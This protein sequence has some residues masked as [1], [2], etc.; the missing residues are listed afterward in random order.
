M[1]K[2]NNGSNFKRGFK[3]W[4][5]NVSLQHRKEMSLQ[6]I[7]PIDPRALA[8][9]LGVIVWKADEVPGIGQKT[10]DVL[11]KDDPESWS[12]MTLC[13]DGK[14]IIVLNPMNSPGRMNSDLTHELSHI[15]IGHEAARID[16]TPDNMLMLRNYDKGQEEEANWL[17]GCLL[18][19]RL[20][21]LHIRK[22]GLDKSDIKKIYGVSAPM[23]DYRLRMTG[24][25]R[26]LSYARVSS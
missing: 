20:A 5:E 6:P 21:M 23:L 14:N 10:L 19:P 8:E 1:S 9:K 15:I 24:V 17:A 2:K 25:D 7:D 3:S 16:V 12:A 18:L 4:C 26:Q 13:G 11:T 22:K